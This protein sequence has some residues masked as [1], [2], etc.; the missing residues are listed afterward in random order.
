MDESC[1]CDAVSCCFLCIRSPGRTLIGDVFWP[2]NPSVPLHLDSEHCGID[3]GWTQ[4]PSP[5]LLLYL[6]LK[7]RLHARLPCECAVLHVCHRTPDKERPVAAESCDKLQADARSLSLLSACSRRMMFIWV[8]WSVVSQRL[9]GGKLR[10]WDHFTTVF[11]IVPPA[12]TLFPRWSVFRHLNLRSGRLLISF[13]HIFLQSRSILYKKTKRLHTKLLSTAGLL[14]W[15]IKTKRKC[16]LSR[17]EIPDGAARI[18]HPSNQRLAT[19]PGLLLGRIRSVYPWL[20]AP[21]D[22]RLT[23]ETPQRRRVVVASSRSAKHHTHT[24]TLWISTVASVYICHG[25]IRTDTATS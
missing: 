5:L 24:H 21:R 16:W 13:T 10:S 18:I 9:Q 22:V 14:L 11:P 6:Y 25:P 2:E 17:G 19:P 3:A 20:T 23:C 4:P 8:R 15:K 12:S 1:N 7:P